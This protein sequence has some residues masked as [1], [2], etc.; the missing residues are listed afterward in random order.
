MTDSGPPPPN[1]AAEL[2]RFRVRTRAEILSILRSLMDQ[3][4]LVTVYFNGGH[5]F[6]LTALLAIDDGGA[7]LTFDRGTDERQNQ[8]LSR[9]P[10]A[11]LEAYLDHI[12]VE[13]SIGTIAT[14][15]FEGKPAFRAPL[16]PSLLRIQRRESYRVHVPISR[17]IVCELPP[18]G[19]TGQPV[20][21]QV[22]DISIGGVAL[23]DFPAAFQLVPGTVFEHCRLHLN[24][25][26]MVMVGLELVRV[27]R[28][29]NAL[30]GASQLVGC[31]FLHLNAKIEAQLQ[32]LINQLDVDRLAG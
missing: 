1:P 23:V 20:L 18:A 27:Y 28:A 4:S 15:G 24:R 14:V 17:P 29:R 3:N 12:R 31:R 30:P 26:E 6:F 8:R 9:A 25:T 32:R 5:D 10:A 19:A 16:P 2:E 11:R 22:R 7:T 13:F 21:A